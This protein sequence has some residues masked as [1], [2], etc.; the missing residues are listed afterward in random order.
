MILAV[1]ESLWTQACHSFAGW[2]KIWLSY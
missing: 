1:S 2:W